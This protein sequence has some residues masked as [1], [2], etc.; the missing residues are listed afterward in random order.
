MPDHHS[1]FINSNFSNIAIALFD[2]S[3]LLPIWFSNRS[4]HFALA[5]IVALNL[6]A[7]SFVCVASFLHCF[8]YN[9]RS[10]N[11]CDSWKSDNF[12]MRAIKKEAKNWYQRVQRGLRVITLQGAI[13]KSPILLSQYCKRIIWWHHNYFVFWW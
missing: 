5:K 2:F 9:Y 1:P 4:S 3:L 13:K 11:Y 8:P 10:S 7:L 6:F 12:R